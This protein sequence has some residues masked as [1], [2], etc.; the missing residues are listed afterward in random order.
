[1]I[2]KIIHYCW[3]GG[4][5]KPPLIKKC[6]KSWQ[7]KM[8]DYQLKEWNEA[9]FDININLFV[10]NAYKS[11]KWAF[12]SD[13]CR[14][15][16]LY[17]YGGI[18]LDTDMEILKSLD[19][20]LNNNAF[21]GVEKGGDKDYINMAI[22]G[23]DKNDSFLQKVLDQYSSKNFDD[24]KGDLYE[25]AI[26]KILTNTAIEEGFDLNKL[27]NLLLNKTVIYPSEYF[28]PKAHSWDK[29]IITRNTYSIHH[30]EG[31]WRTSYEIVRSKIKGILV[32][33]LGIKIANKVTE[34]IKKV[35]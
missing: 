1:M 16:V 13:Y 8:P 22:W 4:S 3:F 35:I 19:D 34:L 23:C 2:P 11:K 21:G 27:P 32:K 7:K 18:Y 10:E 24:Y 33:I 20:F 30:Y 29:P 28:Y 9:N 26:P 14:L 12:V 15:W 5:E 31:S 25:L 6:I 17:N